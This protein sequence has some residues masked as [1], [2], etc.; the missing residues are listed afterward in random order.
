MTKD[1]FSLDNC[2]KSCDKKLGEISYSYFLYECKN[3]KL[4]FPI[5]KDE[6]FDKLNDFIV[7]LAE[8]YFFYR[9]KNQCKS[10]DLSFVAHNDKYISTML[11]AIYENTSRYRSLNFDLG[12]MLP[13]SERIF[14]KDL[15]IKEENLKKIVK[16]V[17][18]KMKVN[19][20]TVHLF[21]GDLRFYAKKKNDSDLVIFRTK[22]SQV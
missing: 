17:D 5:F 8:A 12:T 9:E 2:V 20:K 22:I 10:F 14:I 18:K 16:K 21:R 4:K 1:S 7:R 6:R 13:V 11:F 19:L 3:M 15:R